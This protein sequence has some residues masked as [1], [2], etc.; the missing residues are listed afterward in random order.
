[1]AS[2]PGDRHVVVTPRS[3]A[4]RELGAAQDTDRDLLLRLVALLLVLGRALRFQLLDVLQMLLHVREHL[5]L[6]D[7]PARSGGVW[8]RSLHGYDSWPSMMK[9]GGLYGDFEPIPTASRLDRGR[10]TLMRS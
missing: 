6:L 3:T 2:G 7:D 9:M 10:A 4:S 8:A 1:M 5:L